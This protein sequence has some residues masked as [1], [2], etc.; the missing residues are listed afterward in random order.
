M[1]IHILGIC[2]T[3]MAGLAQILKESGHEVSGSDN[4][5]YPPM[6]DYIRNIGI[7]T[8]EGYSK[9]DLPKADLYVIGNALSRGNE[10]VEE[11][12][13]KKL[14]FVSGPE[15]L[16]RELKSRDVF[17][18]SGTHGK[19]TTSY[20]LAHIF[21]DQGKDV[22][23]LIGGISEQFLD[24]AKLGT[25]KI[26]VIEADEYDSAF[27]DK[28]SKFIHYSPLNLIINNIEFDHADIFN[29]IND[30][31]KQFHH[32][33]KIIPKSGSLIYFDDDQNS[34]DVIKS[35]LWC[36]KVV[37]GS[38]HIAIDILH[39]ALIVDKKK[40]SL[41]DMPL[42]GEHNFKNYVCAILA[43]TKGGLTIEQSID[44]LKRF[45]GVKRRMDL[46]ADISNIKVYDDFAHH[47]TAIQMSSNSLK[48]KY[49][50]K[51]ILGIVE[52]GSNTMSSGYHKDNLIESLKILDK[53]FLLDHNNVYDYFNGFDSE[54]KMLNCIKAEI[55]E[56]DIILIMTNKDS[57]KFIKPI[58][59]SLEN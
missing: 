50:S 45:R 41:K 58:L 54:E 38:D 23:Y 19:T 14:P 52:L 15:M 8:F 53:T 35:G 43:A 27:F 13:E 33:V 20:M 56:Y 12:L 16:G 1:R 55:L 10:S 31:K 39:K 24:S 46:V 30:I 36:D 18:V 2:G 47:P 37:I 3:F 42:S 44:S 21:R 7:K 22:G 51:K 28:R 59:D 6:S 26:F 34:S 5:F 9:K 29:N 32:L 48:D 11:I 40:Y 17:A 49:P 57:Q 25:D 4:Q